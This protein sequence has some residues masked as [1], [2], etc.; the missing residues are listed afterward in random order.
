ML[1]SSFEKENLE[2]FF[3]YMFKILENKWKEIE[4]LI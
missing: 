3:N 1:N 4:H 2:I